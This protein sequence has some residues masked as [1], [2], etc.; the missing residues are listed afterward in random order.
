[1]SYTGIPPLVRCFSA[2]ALCALAGFAYAAEAGRVVF[3]TG[4]ARTASR[5]L[6]TG[7]A[8]QEGD[9]I[10]TGAGGFVYVRTVDEGLLIVRPSSK[11]RIVEYHVDQVNPSNTRVKLELLSGVARSVSGKAVKQARQNFRFNTPVAAIGVRGTDFT[12][13]TD[14]ETSSVTVL[15][16]A[17]VVSGFGSGCTPGGSG[18]CESDLSRELAAGQ[19]GQMLQVRRGQAAPRLLMGGATPDSVAPPRSDEPVAKAEAAPRAPANVSLDPRKVTDLIAQG[20][21]PGGVVSPPTVGTAEPPVQGPVA[22]ELIW[23]R[24]QRVGSVQPTL[25]ENKTANATL[26]AR[27][28]YYAIYRSAG[29]VFEPPVQGSAGFALKNAEAFIVNENTFQ[30]TA[31]NVENGKLEVDF[32]KASFETSFDLKS[33]NETFHLYSTGRVARD[34]QITG[35]GQFAP[36]NNMNVNGAIA[37]PNGNSA[38]YIFST[39]IDAHRVG[40]GATSWA[41]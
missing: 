39:R 34:G 25:D 15:S 24:W 2:V 23:G 9:E 20:L 19:A 10:S 17:I 37:G 28:P 26:I 13:Y 38:A 35:D 6:A 22:A 41:R 11:A 4:E 7:D 30:M 33:A 29:L 36:S 1:M 8:L 5:A 31:A 27:S 40:Q 14:Q 18:P 32:G 3:V 12:V 16:G 21:K